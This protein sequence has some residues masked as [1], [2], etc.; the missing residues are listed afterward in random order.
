[1]GFGFWERNDLRDEAR[2]VRDK[3]EADVDVKGSGRVAA[4]TVC[5]PS[6]WKSDEVGKMVVGYSRKR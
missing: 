6:R 5:Y 1:M 4:L 2:I 3:D